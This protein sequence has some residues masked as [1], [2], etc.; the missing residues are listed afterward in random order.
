MI[1][2]IF[3]RSFPITTTAAADNVTPVS[4]Y[5]ALK[6]TVAELTGRNSEIKVHSTKNRP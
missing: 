5:V 1:T 2:N 6:F 4:R 3:S